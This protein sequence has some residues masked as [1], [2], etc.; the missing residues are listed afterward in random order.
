[1][2]H[3]G[4]P[5][6]GGQINAIESCLLVR[7]HS[8]SRVVRL[9]VVTPEFQVVNKV[10]TVAEILPNVKCQDFR[11]CRNFENTI[12]RNQVL[13]LLRTRNQI[14]QFCSHIISDCE[15]TIG[16]ASGLHIVV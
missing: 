8:A 5:V 4:V 16:F 11:N 15:N 9:A 2:V 6:G 12:K 7:R 13:S 1:M 3:N 10:E 14:V